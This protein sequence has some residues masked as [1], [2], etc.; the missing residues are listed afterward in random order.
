[1]VDKVYLVWEHW[2]YEP[3]QL[4]GI[5]EDEDEAIQFV[6]DEF[7]IPDNHEDK[8]RRKNWQ[9]LNKTNWASRGYGLEVEE[10]E[11]TKKKK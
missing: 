6:L 2:D 11:V 7:V 1:M 10:V 5:F 8:R 9:R 3:S 4:H